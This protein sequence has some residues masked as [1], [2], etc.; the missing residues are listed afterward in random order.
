MSAGFL[1]AMARES[2]R[3]VSA[4]RRHAA[5]RAI[6]DRARAAPPPPPL[7]LHE[8][9][10]LIA[11][12][13]LRSPA[14]GRR[15]PASLMTVPERASAYASAGAAAVSVLTEPTRF[16]GSMDHLSEAARALAPLARPVMRKDFIVDPY[17]LAEA[18]LAGAAG[19]LIVIRLLHRAELESLVL[20]ARALRLFLLLEA[21]DGQDLAT[22]HELV[23]SLGPDG[24]LV[25][26]NC[27]DLATLEVAPERLLA[28]APLLPASLPCVAE[29]GL[30]APDDVRAAV[31]AGYRLVLVGQALMQSAEPAALV[32]DMI[33][34]GR[35]A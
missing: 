35:A 14:A 23:A 30:A 18:R 4:A 2:R 22:V 31:R 21:F 27:R 28:L 29:S 34:A 24:L 33:A 3:R 12:I 26:V 15:F 20:T 5:E 19:A 6:L 17:Q 32:R 9:F 1:Q 10:D 7:V 16:D 11:E 13:K 8:Q 25:G